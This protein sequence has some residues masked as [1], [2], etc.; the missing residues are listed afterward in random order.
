MLSHIL[1]LGQAGAIKTNPLRAKS[2]L[3]WLLLGVT[4]EDEAE[5]GRELWREI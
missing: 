1:A 5:R 2:L 3:F 4:E